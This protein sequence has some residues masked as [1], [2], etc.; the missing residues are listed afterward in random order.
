M[1][2]AGNIV[3]LRTFLVHKYQKFLGAQVGTLF[4]HLGA[5]VVKWVCN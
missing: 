4:N 2:K 5:Q 3:H 1:I